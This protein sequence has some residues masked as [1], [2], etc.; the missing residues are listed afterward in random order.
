M[1]KE[2][3]ITNNYRNAG[4]RGIKNAKRCVS[5]IPI[6][7]VEEYKLYVKSLQFPNDGTDNR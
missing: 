1:N 3:K 7:K 5:L 4:R 6:D 2:K